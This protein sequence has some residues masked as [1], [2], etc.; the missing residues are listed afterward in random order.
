MA[1]LY[2]PEIAKYNSQ[3]TKQTAD[4]LCNL[5]RFLD[6]AGAYR[7]ALAI[8]QQ[9]L[10]IVRKECTPAELASRL[11]S[12]HCFVPLFHLGLFIRFF[13]YCITA[14]VAHALQN[15]RGMHTD[16]GCVQR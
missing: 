8:H 9:A 11:L 2:A 14:I 6:E 10:D 7:P 3:P 5:G 1:A 15:R 4:T 13:L 16:E 12:A